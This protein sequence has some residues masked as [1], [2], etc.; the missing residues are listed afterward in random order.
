MAKLL[1]LHRLGLLL[2]LMTVAIGTFFQGYFFP[3][4]TLVATASAAVACALWL[5]GRR[6]E[7]LA[8]ELPG[9]WVGR[10]LLTLAAWLLIASIWSVYARGNLNLLLQAGAAFLAFVMVRGESSDDTRRRLVWLLSIS[11]LFVAVIGLFEY[12]GFFMHYTTLGDLLHIEPQRDR[13][14]SLFQYPN[15]AA[16]FFLVVILIQNAVLIQ[17]NSRTEKLSLAAISGVVA[18]AFVFTLS[19]GVVIIVPVAALL[20]W[21]GLSAKHLLPSFL[22]LVSAVALPAAVAMYP[23]SKAAPADEWATTLL[24]AL[25]AAAVAALA[26]WTVQKLLDLPRRTLAIAVVA[27]VLVGAAG[28]ILVVSTGSGG[29]PA[30]FSR[31]TQIDLSDVNRDGRIDFLQDA[32]KLTAKRPW[33]YGGG[34]WLRSY[35]QIQQVNYTARDPH[36]HYALTLV[37][38]GVPGLLLLVAAIGVAAFNAFRARKGD[39]LRWAMAAA[40]LTMAAHAAIDIDLSYFMMWLLLWVLLG[41]SQPDAEPIPFKKERRF[42]F[43]AAMTIALITLA[44]AGTL[45]TA[46]YSYQAAQIALLENDND[47]ALKAANRAI[48]LDPLNS[49]YLAMVPTAQN[50]NR[51]LQVDPNNEEL[52]RFVSQISE[53][54][55]DLPSALAAAQKALLLR[56]MSVSHYE[57]VARLLVEQMTTALPRG[58]TDE[59]S[60]YA[61]ELI[62]LGQAMEDRGT[63]SLERQKQAF[64]AYP[65]LTWTPHLNLAVGKANLVAGDTKTAEAKLSAVLKDKDLSTDAA[66]WLH[67]LYTRTGNEEALKALNPQPKERLLQSSLYK[68]LIGLP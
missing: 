52:W 4:P 58:K 26:T 38:A 42:A 29:L 45:A 41:A 40:A 5:L 57:S 66:L 47:A 44:L 17:A 55:D 6:K 68:A 25:V 15:T 16:A 28:G 23:I 39:P 12:S 2:L 8:I 19:R 27:L 63:P 50:L 33:G 64:S 18:T 3:N 11:G 9:G 53:E 20:L 61:Q 56:P 24:F 10:L 51:A 48:M 36:S 65:A 54:Q 14:Y 60:T 59:T 1:T 35:Q 49:Q 32:V 31:V 13:L 46:G 34:G 21:V 67:A 43:P 37:E 62:A 7:R 22:H 30:V